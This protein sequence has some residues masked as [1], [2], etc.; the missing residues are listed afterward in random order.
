MIS[1]CRGYVGSVSVKIGLLMVFEFERRAGCSASRTMGT[2]AYRQALLERDGV[3]TVWVT[4][5]PDYKPRLRPVEAFGLSDDGEAQVGLRDR[6]GLSEVVLSISKPVLLILAQ[7]DGENTCEDI[8]QSFA[9]HLGQPLPVETLQR[10]VEQLAQA[11]LLDGESFDA[12]Y[13]SLQEEYRRGG[14]R[15]LSLAE[16][17]GIPDSGGSLFREILSEASGP[18][19]SGPVRGL[20]APHLD[21]PRG[22]PCYGE[23]YAAIRHRRR[24]DRVVVLGTNH[25]GRSA[26][27][28]ATGNGFVTPFGTTTT[29][30]A[31]LEKLE[32]HCGSL[33]TYE[34]DHLRE[35]SVE[36]QVAWLQFLFGAGSFELVPVLCPDPC[37]PE[38]NGRCHDGQ[39][40]LGDFARALGDLL[41]ADPRD[42]LVVA[43]ADL[44]HV[45]MAFGDEGELD[46]EFLSLVRRHDQGALDRV[47]AGDAEGFVAHLAQ[48]ENPTRV[49][50]A[51]CM[52]ALLTALPDARTTILRY[53]QAV[54]RQTQT[55][56][57]CCAAVL[58]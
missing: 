22:R 36:L 43:G 20:I 57:T 40:S 39:V 27:V 11:H 30:V 10:V 14:T 9:Q 2:M 56:V 16:V 12:H 58:V 35:H 49:C 41:E 45:G 19:M 7:M 50:S 26:R 44:S 55:C 42:S 47:A 52:F 15:G 37:C 17:R 13:S 3:E 1:L 33:R 5:E 21:Y 51:G 18:E 31:F 25:F 6:S 38:M 29:D 46:E 28:V 48:E 8:R 24:P 23:A 34:L 4:W 32:A 53:H 54:D